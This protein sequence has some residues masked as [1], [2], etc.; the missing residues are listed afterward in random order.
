MCSY[1]SERTV[2][3]AIVSKINFVSFLH[4][5]SKIKGEEREKR[6]DLGPYRSLQKDINN[7]GKNQERKKGKNTKRKVHTH[8]KSPTQNQSSVSTFSTPNRINEVATENSTHKKVV[9]FF[10][11][12]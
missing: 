3:D 2:S 1:D 9:F 7:K 4:F 5:Y 8:P 11:S 12:L 10:N 6:K